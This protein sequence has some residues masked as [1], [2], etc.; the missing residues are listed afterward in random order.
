MGSIRDVLITVGIL[1]IRGKS[2][3]SQ[4]SRIKDTQIIRVLQ[5]FVNKKN[6]NIFKLNV[7]K[8]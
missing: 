7:V 2:P 8:I 6:I 1:N 3:R 5:Y 4:N